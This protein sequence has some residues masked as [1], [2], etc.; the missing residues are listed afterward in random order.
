VVAAA[1]DDEDLDKGDE[2]VYSS[3]KVVDSTS[4]INANTGVK[5]LRRSIITQKPVRVLRRAGCKWHNGPACGL[6][7]D[8]L[9]EV[10][11]AADGQKV[12]DK[13]Q[14]IKF[15]LVRVQGQVPI[16]VSKPSRDQI[17]EYERSKR[18]Y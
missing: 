7:Y 18:G 3:V 1:Y 16:D 9:Y 2:L 15:Y 5:A 12:G 14:Q 8:G 10:V 17:S 11:S 6:R 4:N 13:V